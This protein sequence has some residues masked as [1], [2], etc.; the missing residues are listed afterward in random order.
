[1][2]ENSIALTGVIKGRV[3]G[4]FFRAETQRVAESLGLR[5]WCRNTPEGHVEVYLAGDK[6]SVTKMQTWLTKGPE[7]AR[8]DSVELIQCTKLEN[9]I[10]QGF[11]IRY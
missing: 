9:Q 4:V 1:M 3:Q 8:V 6:A 11:E 10:Q 7:L 5:G 2:S